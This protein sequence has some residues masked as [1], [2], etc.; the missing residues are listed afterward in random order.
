MRREHSYVY[1]LLSISYHRAKPA[2]Q[3]ETSPLGG[4][5][6]HLKIPHKQ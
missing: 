4:F 2:L 1:V 5:F 3:L 6:P